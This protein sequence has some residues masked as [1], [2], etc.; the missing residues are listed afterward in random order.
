[1]VIVD[2]YAYPTAV[3]LL[4]GAGVRVVGAPISED[5]TTNVEGMYRRALQLGAAM[6]V[7]MS[8]CNAATGHSLSKGDRGALAQ[9]A[10]QGVTVVDDR[11][12]A[13]FHPSPSPHAIGRLSHSPNIVA[14]GSLT[15]SIGVDYAWDGSAS[16]NLSS[17]RWCGLKAESTQDPPSRPNWSLP[18]L[19]RQHREVANVRRAF[20]EAARH[21]AAEF[22]QKSFEDWR[23]EG[24]N[25]GPSMWIRLPLADAAS[26]VR[27]AYAR[28]VLVGYGGD[29]R[30]DGRPSRHIRLSLTAG[31]HVVLP[32]LSRL[33]I[34]WEEYKLQENDH[35]G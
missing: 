33:S 32:S 34:L 4:R 18:D 12:L 14:V 3:S 29:F 25:V 31:A 17:D 20:L 30:S 13:D 5:G 23:V 1:M 27:F 35:S 7:V 19:L 21:Q 6:V 2:A 24:A 15:N 8:T 16:M 26:F 28:N 9:L 10:E 11:A 22:I